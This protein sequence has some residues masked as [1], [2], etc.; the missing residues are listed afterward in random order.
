MQVTN[1]D[2][3]EPVGL[4]ADERSTAA[5][6]AVAVATAPPGERPSVKGEQVIDDP[7]EA[8]LLRVFDALDRAA[9]PYWVIDGYGE[10]SFDPCDVDIVVPADVLPRR[11]AEILHREADTIGADIVRWHKDI[12][13]VLASRQ[14]Q[15]RPDVLNLHVRSD[16]RRVGRFFYSGEELLADRRGGDSKTS[17]GAP[18]TPVQFGCYLIERIAKGCLDDVRGRQ[19][20]EHY[21]RDP[22]ACGQQVHRFWSTRSAELIVDA[23]SAGEWE[24]VQR[25]L[26]RLRAELRRA[27]A[28]RRPFW[29]AVYFMKKVWMKLRNPWRPGSGLHV[30]LLGPDGAGKSTVLDAIRLNLRRAFSEIRGRSFAP[31][32]SGKPKV[33]GLGQ[34][35]KLPP[36]SLMAGYAKGVYWFFYYTFGY[37]YTVFP[38]KSRAALILNHRY[39]VDALVDCKRYRYRG[40]RWILRFIWWAAPKPDLVILLDAPAEVIQARKQEVPFEETARARDAYRA[41]VGSM[42]NGRIIDASPPADEVIAEVARVI[43]R[44]QA[45]RTASRLGLE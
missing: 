9:V 31:A 20:V 34:P 3:S 13:V 1:V 26:P 27:A 25:A 28:L 43:L 11:L 4:D 45:A 40:P 8:L 32:L 12:H 16:Y 7:R 36:R 29:T 37:F 10:G 19:L 21:Q 17:A 5:V 14:P 6:A 42:P 30:V 18:Q 44:L 39:M 33:R 15:G 22:G 24:P 38:A 35:H 41:L 2:R 23:L